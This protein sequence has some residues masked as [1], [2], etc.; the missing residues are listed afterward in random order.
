MR[1]YSRSSHAALR[2]TSPRCLR[3]LAPPT[4][5]ILG[6]FPAKQGVG[7]N[8][9]EQLQSGLTHRYLLDRELGPGGMATVYLAHDVRHDH[10]VALVV[11]R[12]TLPGM[13]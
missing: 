9:H 1:R 6:D 8:L 10:S 11:L 5:G 7:G 4:A 2:Y 3:L 13:R 12:S